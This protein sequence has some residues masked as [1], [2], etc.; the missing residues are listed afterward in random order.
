MA[1]RRVEVEYSPSI[2]EPVRPG[3]ASPDRALC[4]PT[5]NHFVIVNKTSLSHTHTHTYSIP[6][7]PPSLFPSIPHSLP[8]CPL[9]RVCLLLVINVPCQSHTVTYAEKSSSGCAFGTHPLSRTNSNKITSPPSTDAN[10]RPSAAPSN[11]EGPAGRPAPV[12]IF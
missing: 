9:P 3:A 2:L 4:L 11:P 10:D 7:S 1:K 5:F 12:L 8:L 6:P